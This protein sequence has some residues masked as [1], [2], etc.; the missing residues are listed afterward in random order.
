[1]AVTVA[2]DRTGYGDVVGIRSAG[3]LHAV[4]E[5]HAQCLLEMIW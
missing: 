3:V 4:A 5:V 1:M 2:A